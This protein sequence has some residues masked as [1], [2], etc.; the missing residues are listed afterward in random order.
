VIVDFSGASGDRIDL[1]MLDANPKLAGNQAFSFIGKTAFTGKT[2]ELRYDKK[3]S[4][5]YI[6]AIY[7]TSTAI[8]RP[9]LLSV[10]MAR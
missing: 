8:R 2:G 6:Y 9:T 7:A 5:T 4:D 1:S 10:C 3:A